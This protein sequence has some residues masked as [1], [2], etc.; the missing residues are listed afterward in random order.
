MKILVL[1]I[2]IYFCSPLFPKLGERWFPDEFS[3][4]KRTSQERIARIM[5]RRFWRV[6][7][8]ILCAIGAVL[9]VQWGRSALTFTTGDGLRVL[10]VVVALTAALGRGGWAIQTFGGDTVAERVDRGMYVLGQIG[11]AS[12]LIFVLTLKT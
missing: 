10:A 6:L 5:R 12:L 4:E 11:A 8:L 1:G 7:G 2:C 9:L 3:G